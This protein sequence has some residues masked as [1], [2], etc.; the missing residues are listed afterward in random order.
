MGLAGVSVGLARATKFFRCPQGTGNEG[1]ATG[2]DWLP[3]TVKSILLVR[4]PQAFTDTVR[5]DRTVG[6]HRHGM[7]Q[8]IPALV[9][10]WGCSHQSQNLRSLLA[11][12]ALVLLPTPSLPRSVA[13]RFPSLQQLTV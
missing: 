4:T 5:W 3:E 13:G 12:S 6:G 8:A 7:K 2:A 10:E 1:R 9:Q 11:V